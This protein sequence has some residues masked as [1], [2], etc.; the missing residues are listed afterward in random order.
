MRAFGGPVGSL[1]LSR[2]ELFA[3]G[4]EV[5]VLKNGTAQKKT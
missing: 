1:E 3:S 2:Q 5:K 4:M